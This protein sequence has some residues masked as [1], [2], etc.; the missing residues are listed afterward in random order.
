MG[1]ENALTL[2][3]NQQREHAPFDLCNE[4]KNGCYCYATWVHD[5]ERES[6]QNYI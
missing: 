3:Q 5:Y 1:I 2:R 6:K 4:K